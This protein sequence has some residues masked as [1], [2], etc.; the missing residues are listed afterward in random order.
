MTTPTKEHIR[1]ILTYAYGL[2][3]KEITS[4]ITAWEKIRSL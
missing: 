1:N 3:R 2:R 4:I